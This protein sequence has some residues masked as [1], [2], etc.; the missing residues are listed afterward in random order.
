[1]ETNSRSFKFCCRLESTIESKNKFTKTWNIYW[2]IPAL[3]LWQSGLVELLDLLHNK[4]MK[5]AFS[6]ILSIY[7]FKFLKTDFE[8]YLNGV[9]FIRI[10][11]TNINV[12]NIQPNGQIWFHW[13]EILQFMAPRN[14]F[15]TLKARHAVS[16]L[17]TVGSL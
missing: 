15:M 3:P 4:A 12:W 17:S 14:Y 10:R 2:I 13:K 6:N 9:M 1:M 8:K 11:F 5:T 7:F 16:S